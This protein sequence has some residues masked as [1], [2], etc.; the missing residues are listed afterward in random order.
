MRKLRL[1]FGGLYLVLILCA[2]LPLRAQGVVTAT[3]DPSQTTI[4]PNGTPAAS[5]SGDVP[6][7]WVGLAAAAGAGLIGLGVRFGDSRIKSKAADDDQN[8]VTRAAHE[9]TDIEVVKADSA[10]DL[11]GRQQVSSL[12]TLFS[13]NIQATNATTAAMRESSG[14]AQE[15]VKVMQ[16]A[17]A[18]VISDNALAAKERSALAAQE[19]IVLSQ[20]QDILK[21]IQTSG[22]DFGKLLSTLSET[23]TGISDQRSAMSEQQHHIDLLEA[24]A[25]KDRA[26]IDG[27][28]AR[29]DDLEQQL[30]RSGLIPVP[31]RKDFN[32]TPF[33]QPN[34]EEKSVPP[35]P[36]DPEEKKS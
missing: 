29:I 22:A 6:I 28:P 32:G 36:S 27:S 3:P 24:Q 21:A 16:L 11:L 18:Q 12:L 4:V 10:G 34:A 2:A 9:A 26:K 14:V 19:A 17:Q 33:T 15:A 8:R 13:D 20:G 5:E 30:I 1:V 25:I 35:T 7:W 31:T 23:L